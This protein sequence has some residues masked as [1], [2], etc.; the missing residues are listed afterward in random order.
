MNRLQIWLARMFGARKLAPHL[1]ERLAAWRGL[2]E[3]DLAVEPRRWV[4]IDTETSGLDALRGKLIA[5]GAVTIEHGAI[6]VAPSFEAV[7]RQDSASARENIELHGIGAA[8]Q[9]QGEDPA[10][11]LMRFLEFARKDPLIAWHARFDAAFLRRALKAH[12]GLRF[13]GEWLDLALL[14]PLTCAESARVR[15]SQSL[16][17]WLARFDI[18]PGARH[19]A[20][21]D[22]YA[23]AQLFQ[24]AARRAS[25]VAARGSRLRLCDLLLLAGEHAAHARSQMGP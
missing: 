7:L 8:A 9:A 1:A 24:I 20:L 25:R 12:L 2:P 17:A 23:T 18:D 16:D 21:A 5:I 14:A 15:S 19:T 4:V 13:G 3:P 11:A 22:A 10:E 6:V